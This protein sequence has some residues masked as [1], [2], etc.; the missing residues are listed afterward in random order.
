MS[1]WIIFYNQN[2]ALSFRYDSDQN[3]QVSQIIQTPL[4]SFLIK[5]IFLRED[6]QIHTADA[7]KIR[8]LK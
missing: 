2:P 1:I 7:E 6:S 4:G 5:K 8:Q 3:L